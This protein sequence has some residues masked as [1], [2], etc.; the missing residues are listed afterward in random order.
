MVLN[1]NAILRQ[2]SKYCL[3]GYTMIGPGSDKDNSPV[4]GLANGLAYMEKFKHG[5]QQ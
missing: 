1:S 2:H 3:Q 4:P 5:R